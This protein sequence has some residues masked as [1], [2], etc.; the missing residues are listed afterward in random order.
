MSKKR[1]NHPNQLT[2]HHILPTSRGGKT[3]DNL[4]YV[5]RRQHDL[6]HDLFSNRTPE[7]IIDYLV[8]DFW[9]GKRDYVSKY[10]EKYSHNYRVERRNK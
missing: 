7:E 10:Q 5:P 9:N 2:N 1:K 8:N 3:L 6:Y 4:C